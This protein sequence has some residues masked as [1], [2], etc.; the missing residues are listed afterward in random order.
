VVEVRLPNGLDIY[1]QSWCSA[2]EKCFTKERGRKVA[3]AR[4]L[5]KIPRP[6]RQE[7]WDAYFS[8]ARHSQPAVGEGVTD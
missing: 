3:L 1:G 2:S 4:A 6:E 5:K 7:V 8:R